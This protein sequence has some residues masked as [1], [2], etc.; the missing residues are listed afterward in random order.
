M[1]LCENKQNQADSDQ[2]FMS[3]PLDVDYTV[4]ISV[5]IGISSKKNNKREHWRF[6]KETAELYGCPLNTHTNSC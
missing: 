2:T 6:V 3:G 1:V 4:D 5:I